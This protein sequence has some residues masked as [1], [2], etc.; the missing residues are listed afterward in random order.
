MSKS[1]HKHLSLEDRTSILIG[2]KEGLSIRKIALTI[3]CS[4][5][6]ISRELKNHRYTKSPNNFNNCADRSACKSNR[7]RPGN[8]CWRTR[9]RSPRAPIWIRSFRSRSDGSS[10]PGTLLRP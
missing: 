2:I 8:T 4:P 7:L 6:T 3:N 5:S 1:K 9:N 10:N